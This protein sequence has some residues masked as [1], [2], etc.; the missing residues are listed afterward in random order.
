MRVDHRYLT[1]SD[2]VLL[3]RLTLYSIRQICWG[4]KL[5][6]Q[7]FFYDERFLETY[8]G[9]I[10]T[11][12]AIAI[13][14]LVANC[15]DAYSTD[16]KITW[17]NV[18]QAQNFKIADNGHGMTRGEFRHIWK[19]F[20]Y[21][22]IA[23]GGKNTES[24][25][26]VKGPPR[27]V[28]GKNGKGRFASFCLSSEYIITSRKAGQEFSCR[29]Y[30]TATDPLVLDEI[31]FIE[32]GVVGHGT[33]I[34]G[35]GPVRAIGLSEEKAR[36]IIGSRFLTNPGFKVSINRQQISFSDI[37]K[38]LSE[39]TVDVP[40]YG[41]AEIL[42]IDVKKSDKSTKQHGI[43]WWVQ[44]RAVGNCK[45]SSSDY[46]RVLDGRSSEAKRF[47]FI[48]Q[49]DFLNEQ[50]AVLEDWS[51][52]KDQNEAW[53]ATRTVIQDRIRQMIHDHGKA[54]REQT[55]DAVIERHGN[56]INRLSP[57]SKERVSK[58]IDEVVE[59][60]PGLGEAEVSQL[61]GILTKLEQSQTR[62]GL[63]ELLHNCE[64]TDYDK[65][66]EILSQWTVG[67]AKVV[68][69][70]IQ[71]R[72]KL[73]GELRFKTKQVG[74]D[75]VHELQPLFERG[76]WMF[77]PQF[78]SIEFTSNV[79]MTKVIQTIFKD[80]SGKGSRNRPD[81]VALPDASVGFYGR[82]S[83]DDNFEQDGVEH[84][85]IIDLKTTGL[86]L[87]S[88]EKNQ[89]WK[90][91]KELRSRGVLHDHARVDGFVL[92]DRIEP[93]ENEATTQGSSVRILPML[94]THILARAEKR[95]LNLHDQVKGSPFLVE[96][97]RELEK[98]MEPVPVRQSEFL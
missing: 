48:V 70:E 55:K 94:Y 65:L 88:R 66:H 17:P 62:Y 98:F 83:Y 52:F 37:P 71:N 25:D 74:V 40:G 92:G 58:F 14:E 47:T 5:E 3:A 24:P 22:R 11:D 29:V 46:T 56:A 38:L 78:E 73:I 54:E 68:L 51:G 79:G 63:L 72:L 27:P 45:W 34:E 86:P 96:Q 53:E 61:T 87:G 30:R 97:Q 77:G 93:G 15:W 44:D 1:R 20:A 7:P 64:P 76:L 12:P 8:A 90:Y 2:C 59:K 32:T 60:C 91:V 42:H 82:P 50:D 26:D 84:V 10:I 31:S 28:F 33:T 75:E 49:A 16:V 4:R 9:A 67:M 85:V 81:F 6:Q 57:V 36:E 23:H 89:V 80:A 21:N 39:A 41:Q 69:D 13:V 18:A 35:Y 43:A 19:T 95:L